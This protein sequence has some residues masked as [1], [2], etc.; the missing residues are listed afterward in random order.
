MKIRFAGIL[1][2]VLLLVPAL[3]HDDVL[4]W[5]D[6]LCGWG[7]SYGD[8]KQNSRE[9][10]EAFAKRLI[11]LLMKTV[12]EAESTQLDQTPDTAFKGP[13]GEAASQI[14]RT[15]DGS[16]ITLNFDGNTFDEAM[17]FFR[18]YSALN[19]VVTRKANDIVQNDSTKVR[20]RLKDVKLRNALELLLTQT[21]AS[22]RYG[23]RNGVLQIGTVED[24]KGKN[25]VLDVIPIDDLLYHPPDFVA[26]EAGLDFLKPKL[27]KFGK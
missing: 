18:D 6:D 5:G 19:I 26:P 7:R 23:I 4:G 15:L 20:L 13:E 1:A 16:R 12:E 24:W 8:D 10:D 11:E 17:D 9:E 22:L 14:A 25:M 27:G 2:A 3:V 21:D